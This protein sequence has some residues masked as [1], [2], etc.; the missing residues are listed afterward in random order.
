[1]IK[2]QREKINIKE[3]VFLYLNCAMEEY[4]K[5]KIQSL[6]DVMKQRIDSKKSD[7]HTIKMNDRKR[8]RD[9]YSVKLFLISLI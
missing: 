7:Y 6:V 9:D 3:D 2:N 5:G 4:I 1:M 8:K